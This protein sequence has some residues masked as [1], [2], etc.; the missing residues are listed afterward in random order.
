MQ[1]HNK[2]LEDK[3]SLLNLLFPPLTTFGCDN[4]ISVKVYAKLYNKPL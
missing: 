2:E 4:T 1:T 3:F